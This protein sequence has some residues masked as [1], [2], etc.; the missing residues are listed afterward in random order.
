MNWLTLLGPDRIKEAG[1][2]QA[3]KKTLPSGVD[4]IEL[5]SGV[6]LKAG[7]KPDID[8]AAYQA[9]HQALKPQL[10]RTAGRYPPLMLTDMDFKKR[11]LDWALRLDGR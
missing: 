8:G 6:M 9:V 2:V 4:I 7:S 11:T 10:E 5:K 1:G 3:L